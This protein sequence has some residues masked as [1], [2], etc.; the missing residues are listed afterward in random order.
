M[1]VYLLLAIV[2]TETVVNPCHPDCKPYMCNGPLSTDCN[3]CPHPL[4]VI[5][6]SKCWCKTGYFDNGSE[7]CS[8]YVKN[9]LELG[10]SLSCVKCDIGR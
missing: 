9:C 6:E 8:L 4:Q 3:A 5:R 2:S 1:S 7:P 10:P